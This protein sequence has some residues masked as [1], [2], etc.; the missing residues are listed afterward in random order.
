MFPE[1]GTYAVGANRYSGAY[2]YA[3]NVLRA[4]DSTRT[5]PCSTLVGDLGTSHYKGPVNGVD[6]SLQNT[7]D[8]TTA[9]TGQQIN[10]LKWNNQQAYASAPQT[11]YSFFG[12]GKWDVTDDVQFFAHA[13][14]AESRTR[15][16][17]LPTNASFG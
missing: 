9:Q 16:L 2:A 13:T 10:T 1:R 3:N 6:Y 14:Y 7:Y 17:L 12:S 5:A 11:R 15:T 4:C 8:T